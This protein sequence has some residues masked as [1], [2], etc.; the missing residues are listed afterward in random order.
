VNVN[1]SQ[2]QYYLSAGYSYNQPSESTALNNVQQVSQGVTTSNPPSTT[3]NNP[4]PVSNNQGGTAPSWNRQTRI[5]YSSNGNPREI[6][7][8]EYDNYISNGWRSIS[9]TQSNQNNQD[10]LPP[11]T[12]NFVTNTGD[13]ALNQLLQQTQQFLD[14][15]IQQGQT[16]NPQVEISEEQAAEFLSQAQKEISPYYNTQMKLAREGLLRAAGYTSDE[17]ATKEAQLEKSYGTNLRT[18]GANAAES[19]MALS[20]GRMLDEQNLAEDTQSEID[21]NRRLQEYN[22]GSQ[23]RQ[24]AGDWGGST[25]P[26]F[27]YASAPKVTA[28][29]STFGRSLDTKPFYNISDSVY[30][31]LKGSRQYEQQTSERQRASELEGAWRTTEENRLRKLAL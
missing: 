9:P 25:L 1:D 31:G 15:L 28:G 6:P 17:I 23:A 30:Q 13:S 12:K 4:A 29:Q 22:M 11:V 14:K 16:I 5:V 7:A 20:G 10:N 18:L 24:F 2:D 3:Q 8:N 27:S 21:Q 26:E 19:G